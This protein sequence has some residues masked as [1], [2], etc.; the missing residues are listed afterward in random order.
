M[1][2]TTLKGPKGGPLVKDVVHRRQE[3]RGI[4]ELVFGKLVAADH[5]A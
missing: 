3:T 2:I 4:H 1:P 5:A